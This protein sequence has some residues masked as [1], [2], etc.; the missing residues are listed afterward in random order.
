MGDWTASGPGTSPGREGHGQQA[1]APWGRGPKP[2][3][4]DWRRGHLGAGDTPAGRG[5]AVEVGEGGHAH[6]VD[7]S[8]SQPQGLQP[9]PDAPPE[10]KVPPELM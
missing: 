4:Q 10:G 3:P 8:L 2:H 9:S 6:A 7:L 5:P 1:S